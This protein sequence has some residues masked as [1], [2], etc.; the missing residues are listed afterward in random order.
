MNFNINKFDNQLETYI[1]KLKKNGTMQIELEEREER[2]LYYQKYDANKIIDMTEDE[3]HEYISKLWAMI[4]WGNKEYIIN[5]YIED[6]G[7]DNLKKSI[8]EL[9]YGR[10]KIENRWDKFNKNIKGFGPAMMSELLCYIYPFDC[11]IWNNTSLLAY[12]YLE[13]KDLPRYNYQETGKK[14]IELCSYCKEMLKLA[15]NKTNSDN[16]LLFIDYLFW[17]NLKLYKMSKSYIEEK[18]IIETAEN[19]K[20]LHTELKEKVRD[21]GL[22]LGFDASNEVKIGNGAVVDV[23]WDFSINNVGKVTYVFEVQTGGSIDS[24]IMNLLKASK[25]KNVQGIIA[26]SD[27]TQL[28]NIRKESEDIFKNENK[29]IQLWDQDDVIDVYDKLQSVNQSVNSILKIDDSLGN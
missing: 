27:A 1:K 13:I 6:N 25:Y 28:E 4:I 24:L 14:Y 11:M 7:F 8:A 18:P 5:K 21:I 29:K 15:N 23:V 12:Q 22:F 10:D 16:D 2:K 26:V 9:L 19:K 3:F 17:D 20:S